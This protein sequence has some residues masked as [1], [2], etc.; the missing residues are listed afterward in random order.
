MGGGLRP[1]FNRSH[2]HRR[3]K[4]KLQSPANV[5]SIND[6][7]G[8]FNSKPI[9]MEIALERRGKG[10]MN[11]GFVSL[12]LSVRHTIAAYDGVTSWFLIS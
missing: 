9:N 6:F 11:G 3:R 10:K 5:T 8:R 7:K 12:Q 1:T 4:G 2:L